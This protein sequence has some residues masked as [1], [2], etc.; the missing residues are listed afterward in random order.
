MN[1]LQKTIAKLFFP[2]SVYEKIVG[3]KTEPDIPRMKLIYEDRKGRKFYTFDNIMELPVARLLQIESMIGVAEYGTKKSR[4]ETICNTIR[5][6]INKS[7]LVTIAVLNNEIQSNLMQ[8]AT[9]NTLMDLAAVI[10]F[11]HNDDFKALTETKIQE[12]I[13]YWKNSSESY[14]FF[15]Q[16]AFSCTNQFGANSTTDIVS[17]LKAVEKIP[18]QKNMRPFG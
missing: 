1:R 4:L 15:L 5:E 3:I 10:T 2:K 17:Y 13:N 18:G 6:S 12:K 9:E 14:S 11:D 7:D 8:I 16:F